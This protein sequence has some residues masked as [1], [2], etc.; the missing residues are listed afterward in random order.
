[1]LE[2]WGSRAGAAVVLGTWVASTKA[3]G[4]AVIQGDIAIVGAAIIRGRDTAIVGGAAIQGDAACCAVTLSGNGATVAS[5]GAGFATAL[6]DIALWA[7]VSSATVKGRPTAIAEGWI[8]S[9][10][11]IMES[12]TGVEPHWP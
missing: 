2:T 9:L 11:G 4:D 12:V 8:F 1:V 10:A 7:A 5:I 3:L 6:W